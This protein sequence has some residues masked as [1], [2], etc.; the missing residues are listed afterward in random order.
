[1]FQINAKM[2]SNRLT[3]CGSQQ[4]ADRKSKPLMSFDIHYILYSNITFD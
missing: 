3:L 2:N 4:A 1:M